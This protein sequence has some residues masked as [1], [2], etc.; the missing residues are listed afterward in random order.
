M[1]ADKTARSIVIVSLLGNLLNMTDTFILFKVK[2]TRY[3][4]F[5]KNFWFIYTVKDA[6]KWSSRNIEI[7]ISYSYLFFISSNL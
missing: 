5:I 4:I 3:Y 7:R 6:V 2:S 1:C